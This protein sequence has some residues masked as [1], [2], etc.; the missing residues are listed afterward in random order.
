[1]AIPPNR[2]SSFD[3]LDRGVRSEKEIERL[4][5]ERRKRGICVSCGA[6][7]AL[8]K[9]EKCIMCTAPAA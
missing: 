6:R 4:R 8:P 7:Y 9:S 3:Y 2:P 1:M 5:E